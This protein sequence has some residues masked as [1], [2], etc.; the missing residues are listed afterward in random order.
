MPYGSRLN[1]QF[2]LVLTSD[3]R[4]LTIVHHLWSIVHALPVPSLLPLPLLLLFPD[5]WPPTPD[6]CIFQSAF[7]TFH[8]LFSLWTIESIP[9]VRPRIIVSIPRHKFLN[10]FLNRRFRSKAHVLLQVIDVSISLGHVPRL[11]I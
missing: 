10:T 11:Q 6:F 7:S 4:P 9:S 1:L 5:P 2:P 8:F 3:I